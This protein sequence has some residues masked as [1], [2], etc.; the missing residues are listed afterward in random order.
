MSLLYLY[1]LLSKLFGPRFCDALG[2]L[3]QRQ[4]SPQ[5]YHLTACLIML[6]DKSL[7]QHCYLCMR[8]GEQQGGQGPLTPLEGPEDAREATLSHS[9]M[10]S[11]FL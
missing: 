10:R 9:R 3:L 11:N 2:L 7:Y 5:P 8:Q 4:L 1:H 6:L